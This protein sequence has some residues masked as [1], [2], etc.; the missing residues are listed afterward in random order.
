[1]KENQRKQFQPS[2]E[3]KLVT[4]KQVSTCIKKLNPKKATEVDS[5]PPKMVKAAMPSLTLPICNIANTML[6]KETFPSQLKKAQVTP[7]YKKDDTFIPKNY[8]P[9]SILPSLSKIYERLLSDQLTAHFQDIFD[10]YLSAFP[11][12]YGCQTTFLCIVEDW[13][14]ALDKTCL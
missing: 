14:E 4:E 6:S 2:F 11:T 10:S 7:I 9:V 1:M 8:R 12:S 13:K 5:I 3:F